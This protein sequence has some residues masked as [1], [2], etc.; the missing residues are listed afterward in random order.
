MTHDVL[1]TIVV[2][3]FN[4]GR[5]LRGAIESATRQTHPHV[6]VI[7]VDDGSTDE[8]EEVLRSHEGAVR[9]VRKPNGGQAS[10]LNVGLRESRG[11]FVCFL[12]SDDLLFPTAIEHA[13]AASP[14]GAVAKVHWPLEEIDGNGQRTGNVR[15][16]ARLAHGNVRTEV[17]ENGP[18]STVYPPTSG[19]LWARSFLE[20]VFPLS[21]EPGYRLGGSDSYLSN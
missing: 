12:D 16:S 3:N 15:P 9:V 7:V 17:V 11:E 1:A 6:E 13:L 20:R 10:S 19:N 14:G 18:E 2:N 21:E 4:Y 5:Y 8:S